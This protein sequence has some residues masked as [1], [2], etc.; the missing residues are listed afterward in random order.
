MNVD[1]LTDDNF[2]IPFDKPDAPSCPVCDGPLVV[3]VLQ[4]YTETRMPGERGFTVWCE[5][6]KEGLFGGAP[7]SHRDWDYNEL[8]SAIEETRRWFEVEYERKRAWE[9]VLFGKSE[10]PALE[11]TAYVF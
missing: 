11:R 4:R 5:A 7:E 10:M 1:I 8:L 6:R 9:V 2:T 3:E